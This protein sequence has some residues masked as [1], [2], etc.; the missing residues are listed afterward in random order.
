MLPWMSTKAGSRWPNLSH[1]IGPFSYFDI[2]VGLVLLGLA[3]LATYLGA[4]L[5]G[6]EILDLKLYGDTWFDSDVAVYH[7]TLVDPQNLRLHERTYKHPLLSFAFCLPVYFLRAF[8]VEPLLSVRLMMAGTAALWQV[9]LFGTLRLMGCRLPE[10][11]LLALLGSVSAAGMFWLPVLESFT[12]GS[13]GIIWALG[14]VAFTDRQL[15]ANSSAWRP[16][17]GWG[18]AVS[19]M[20]L[21]ITVTN[22]FVGC[23]AIAL[24]YS[25]KRAVQI[26]VLAAVAVLLFAL[27]QHAIF[28]SALP[29]K[30]PHRELKYIASEEAGGLLN[31]LAAFICHTMVMPAIKVIGHPRTGLPL[32]SVQFSAPGTGSVVGSLAIGL[33]LALIALGLWQLFRLKG[34]LRLRLMVG[35]SLLSQLC[36]HMVYTGRETFLYSLHFLPLWIGLAAL[37]AL[38]TKRALFIGLVLS[39]L[40]SVG[41]NNAVQFNRAIAFYHGPQVI[42]QSQ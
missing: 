3:G 40:I 10:A 39:L 4:R 18:V 22:W 16:A 1:K 13:V 32:M 33:W 36:L 15:T 24:T 29:M 30:V 25:R 41:I 34:H 28:G 21:S 27:V 7:G 2:F 9:S 11:V 37:G 20:T 19:F 35:I 42:E 5:I 23:V 12:L 26:T 31:I 17:W 8:H 6:P 14:W 38:T